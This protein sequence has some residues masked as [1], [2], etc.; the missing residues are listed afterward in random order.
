MAARDPDP[1]HFLAAVQSVLNQTVRDLE[2]IVVDDGSSSPIQI[3]AGSDLH[4]AIVRQS[5]QGVSAARNRGILESRGE[6]IAF[7]DSDDVW[8]SRK[9]EKQI[10]VMDSDN[11]IGLS[12]TARNAIDAQSALISEATVTPIPPGVASLTPIHLLATGG[13]RIDGTICC[14]EAN[15]DM[16]A[17]LL[18]GNQCITTS[19]V[20]V[21][22]DALAA[23][24]LFDIMLRYSEDYDMWIKIARTRKIAQITSCEASYRWH[25]AN[26][27]AAYRAALCFDREMYLKYQ[28]F[29]ERCENSDMIRQTAT[30]W[31][32][33][34]KQYSRKAFD[35]AR[36][37][38]KQK[39]LGE[40]LEHALWSL[41]LDP[42][43][44]LQC[45]RDWCLTRLAWSYIGESE[46]AGDSQ[47]INSSS[48]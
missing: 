40:G 30:M 39:R 45:T 42:V 20:M 41:A 32:N 16:N 21:R 22:R 28:H 33:A 5:A 23:T 44:F 15:R 12:F 46:K 24:G 43:Y 7:L 34:R 35:Q 17:L 31:K 19:T 4:V 11:D 37:G 27:M 14:V 25:G 3:V 2:L 10:V 1:A 36:L 8:F 9:L 29:A 38:L 18:V 48:R 6:Y 26:S 47:M 13:E